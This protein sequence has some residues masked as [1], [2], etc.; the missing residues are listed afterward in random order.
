MEATNK[1]SNERDVRLRGQDGHRSIQEECEFNRRKSRREN[2]TRRK[3]DPQ[4]MQHSDC[5]G[6]HSGPVVERH[7]H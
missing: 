4:G 2:Q 5:S 3:R 6:V 7:V 1:Q